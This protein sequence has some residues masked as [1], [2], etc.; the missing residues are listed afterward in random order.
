MVRSFRFEQYFEKKIKIA[1]W[2]D[3]KKSIGDERFILI[4]GKK[5]TRQKDTL[6]ENLKFF[7]Y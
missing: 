7:F 3:L 4:Q 2:L 1:N 6:F 5:N